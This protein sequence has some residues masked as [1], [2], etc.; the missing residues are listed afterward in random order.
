MTTP[1]ADTDA[2]RVAEVAEALAHD[3]PILALLP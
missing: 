2:L 1:D 3:I